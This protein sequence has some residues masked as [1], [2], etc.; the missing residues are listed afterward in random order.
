MFLNFNLLG[1]IGIVS[2]VNLGGIVLVLWRI[3]VMKDILRGYILANAQINM[4]AQMKILESVRPDDE[5]LQ[6]ILRGM[7]KEKE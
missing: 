1:I 7:K 6:E 3:K 4:M 2:L 5:E